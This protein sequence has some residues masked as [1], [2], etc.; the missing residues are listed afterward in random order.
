MSM[1][2]SP[3]LDAIASLLDRFEQLAQLDADGKLLRLDALP[4]LAEL[5]RRLTNVEHDR[6]ALRRQVGWLRD[7][8]LHRT[9]AQLARAGHRRIALYGGGY[10]TIP[11]VRQPWLE[12][13]IQVICIID[14][15]RRSSDIRGVPV[16]HPD[17]LPRGIDAVVVSSD[18]HEGSIYQHAI[19]RFGQRGIHVARIYA[20]G[21]AADTPEHIQR[22]L[23][24]RFD[25]PAADAEWLMANRMERHDA[26]LPMLP[27]R[28][29]ELH[30]RRYEF[31]LRSA[32]GMRVIDVACGTGYGSRLLAE[33]GGAADVIGIDADART[34]DYATRRH[35]IDNHVR[36]MTSDATSLPLPDRSADLMVSF[37]TIEHLREPDVFLEQI[38]RILAVD[39]HAIISTPNDA[40]PT[41]H[42]H[43]S[44]T[45]DAFRRLLMRHFLVVEDWGQSEQDEPRWNGAPPGI[46]PLT[47]EAP[48]PDDIISIVSSPKCA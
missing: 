17:D 7:R 9:A 6:D 4:A 3:D 31:A 30:M 46:Y 28:R 13:G 35:A 1:G 27:A 42:H 19:R 34:I 10:H 44:F 22:T 16:Y 18:R 8:I 2:T 26:S 12:H 21:D 48:R 15:D 32:R 45:R 23:V 11:I 37:E 29:T 43:H 38:A 5:Q 41:P 24:E 33:R 39:G 14:D 20:V 25:V 40:G 47:D 36:F